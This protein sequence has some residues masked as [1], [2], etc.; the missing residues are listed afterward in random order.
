MNTTTSGSPQTT[1][2]AASSS[3]L[4]QRKLF[5]ESQIG[6]N[7]FH[8]L[9][10][11]SLSQRPGIAPY[12]IILGDVKEKVLCRL[13]VELM[14]NYYFCELHGEVYLLTYML[15][16]WVVKHYHTASL[17]KPSAKSNVYHR[18]GQT[19]QIQIVSCKLLCAGCISQTL[20]RPKYPSHNIKIYRYLPSKL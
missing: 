9:L 19:C 7:S 3:L 14:M 11:P 20:R 2:R 16:D 18:S 6:R 12:R 15:L 4:A 5:A 13:S 1:P 10:E 8:K 17:W